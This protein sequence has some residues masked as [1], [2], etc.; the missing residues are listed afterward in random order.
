MD[1]KIHKKLNVIEAS[2]VIVGIICMAVAAMLRVHT[3]SIRPLFVIIGSV[4]E[5]IV[6]SI[7]LILFHLETKKYKFFTIGYFII[8]LLLLMFMNA[9]IPFSGLLV[10]LVFCVAKNVY[11][12]LKVDE[13]YQPLGYYE[14]C[15]KY[16]IKVKKPRKAR[17]SA[18]KKVSVSTRHK[19]KVSVKEEPNFA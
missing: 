7:E 12:D 16:G 19:K 3:L 11:R 18:S 17:V 13:I 14:L 1:K 15:K 6:I 2:S 5:L 9:H 4:V 8:D 10:V